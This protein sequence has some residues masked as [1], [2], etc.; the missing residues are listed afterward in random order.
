[1]ITHYRKKLTV[2]RHFS[3]LIIS[4]LRP[5]LIAKNLRKKIQENEN[6]EE[7]YKKKKVMENRK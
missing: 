3:F 1:M 5:C 2:I 7:K 4:T 6:R